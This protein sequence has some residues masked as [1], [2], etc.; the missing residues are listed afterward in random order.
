MKTAGC[1][2]VVIQSKVE[3][4]GSCCSSLNWDIFF[5]IKFCVYWEGHLLSMWNI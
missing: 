2:I 5:N 3:R 4:L 1:Q